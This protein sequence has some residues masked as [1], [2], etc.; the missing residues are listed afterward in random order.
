MFRQYQ[1]LVNILQCICDSTSVLSA[2]R[3]DGQYFRP[4]QS[5]S[6]SDRRID[7][8]FLI[9]L[10]DAHV[11]RYLREREEAAKISRLVG[12]WMHPV[13]NISK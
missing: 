1:L 11:R 12:R 3:T 4:S 2:R 13:H 10:Q 6:P 9:L 5:P 7:L 8:A